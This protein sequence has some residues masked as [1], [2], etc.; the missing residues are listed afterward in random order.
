[1]TPLC[2]FAATLT[3]TGPCDGVIQKAHLIRAQVIRRE[4][5]IQH[6]WDPR[7]WVPGCKRHHAMLDWSRQ[8]RI[9]R[10]LIPESV[11]SAAEDFG[12]GWWLDR[13]YGQRV[14]AA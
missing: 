9:P 13:E 1:M 12:V 10:E 11:E 14:E 4:A 6:I 5:G 7:V 8:L 3:N 2:W